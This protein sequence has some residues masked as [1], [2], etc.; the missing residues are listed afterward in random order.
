M[1]LAIWI[2]TWLSLLI[3][4]LLLCFFIFRN[5]I[6]DK[7]FERVTAKASEKKGLIISVQDK[8]FLSFFNVGIKGLSVSAPDGDTILQVD[9]LFLSPRLFSLLR[10]NIE[11]SILEIYNPLLTIYKTSGRDNISFLLQGDTL[12]RDTLQKGGLH[13]TLKKVSDLFFNQVP[14]QMNIS[15]LKALVRYHDK[16]IRIELPE[17][18][19]DDNLVAAMAVLPSDSV[20]AAFTF[21]G[22]VDRDEH[23][24][25]GAVI[26]DSSNYIPFL[27]KYYNLEARADTLLLA[28]SESRNDEEIF[29]ASGN[30]TCKGLFANHWRIAPEPVIVKNAGLNYR[31]LVAGDSIVLDQESIVRV[32]ELVIRPQLKVNRG[33]HKIYSADIRIPETNAQKLFS[34]LPEG[35]FENIRGMK[36]KGTLAFDLHFRYDEAKLDSLAFHCSMHPKDFSIEQYGN[37]DLRKMNG[38]FQYTAYEKDRAVRS[39]QVGPSN[40]YFTPLENIS[41]YLVAAVMTSEDGSFYYH[42]GFNEDAFRKSIIENIREKRFKRGGSTISMQLVKNVFLT[43]NKNVSRKVEEALIT[44]LIEQNR[45]VSKKRMLEVYLNIIEWGPGVYGIGE[46]S[47]F[48]FDKSP[49]ALDLNESI[50][51]AMIV[52][53]PKG[54]R[55]HFD[56]HGHLKAHCQAYYNLLARHLVKKNVITEEQQLNLTADVSLAGPAGKMIKTVSD[57]LQPE[58]PDLREIKLPEE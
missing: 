27:K 1:K 34:S 49:S 41:P 4:I 44:W 36:V 37:T 18:V 35:I 58:E 25:S 51:L 43:R 56:E 16:T 26:P 38:E 40:P 5:V 21:R 8:R 46:A 45:L 22:T 24:I 11:F 2:A 52:P 57:T 23:S 6:L 32:N 28:F 30:I 39:F 42:K 47:R 9:S 55:Y 50:F 53:Q 19:V 48:Y 13:L 54:F 29:E 3:L 7:A 14:D 12:D 31:I 33:K 10:S 17:M 15:G 20:N